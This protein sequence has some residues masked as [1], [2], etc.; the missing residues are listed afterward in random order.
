MNK[1]LLRVVEA[2]FLLLVVGL[3]IVCG[4]V[5]SAQAA[6]LTSFGWGDSDANG[7]FVEGSA[8]NGKPSYYNGTYYIC[9]TTDS[10]FWTFRTVNTCVSGLGSVPYY[11]DDAVATPDLATDWT[12]NGGG[13][14][15]GTLTAPDEGGGSTTTPSGPTEED[16]ALIVILFYFVSAF[17]LGGTMWLI[18]QF[19]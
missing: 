10:S 14:P 15:L 1:I 8:I 7:T 17:T 19:V 4:F 5:Y 16:K 13:T 2:I 3:G 11:S 18:R 6:D 9:W 12:D